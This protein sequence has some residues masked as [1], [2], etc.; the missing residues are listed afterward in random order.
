MFKEI[1]NFIKNK[2]E[3]AA[4]E[5]FFATAVI[6]NI[7]VKL[8]KFIFITIPKT[9]VGKLDFIIGCAARYLYAYITPL[10]ENQIMFIC[11]Q[12]DYTCNPKYIIDNLLTRNKNYR[13]VFS[14][15]R[16]TLNTE[17]AVPDGIQ[18][19][20]Q[21]SV[22]YYK[23]IMRSKIIVANSVEFQKKPTPKRKGQIY[24][25]TWHGSL[26]IKRFGAKENSGKLWV[27]AANRCG[28]FTDYILSNSDFEDCVY[29]DTFWKN[30]P[31]LR[32]G[33]PRNDILVHCSEDT[34]EKIRKA[35]IDTN[36]EF[37]NKR[38][39]LYAPTF[40][41]N[42]SLK[43]YNIDTQNL[44]QALSER[45]GGEWVILIRMHPTV[46]KHRKK[47]IK[48][49]ENILDVTNYPDI[50]ELIT[51]SDVA[52]TDYSSWI[53]D[54]VL[55]GRPGFIYAPDIYHYVTERGFYYPLEHTPFPI[56]K[57]NFELIEQ[58]LNFD[59]ENYNSK[60]KAFIEDKGC[61]EDG[62]A[63]ERTVNK[64]IELMEGGK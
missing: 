3:R 35:V 64:I 11:F 5:G 18:L 59:S 62:R 50:Q 52:I 12:G 46:R 20:E 28:K 38:F 42:H 56:S 45:F 10:D 54:F 24:I 30:T 6:K 34:K 37:L 14:A 16:K 44:V 22:N 13:I 61:T 40:R 63:S 8:P 48:N 57:N 15:R 31:I 53:Y 29:R 58:V 1:I 43:Y 60:V 47:F 39:A 25:E 33:H 36:V 26:G 32:Y 19:V 2:L 9:I 55:T 21:Y 23:E 17:G 27:Y 7:F 51:I 49:E 41:D 4:F